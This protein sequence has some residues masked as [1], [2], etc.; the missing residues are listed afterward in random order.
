[1]NTATIFLPE[2]ETD[3]QIKKMQGQALRREREIAEMKL[4]SVN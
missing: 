1:M 3:Q 4:P 2:N